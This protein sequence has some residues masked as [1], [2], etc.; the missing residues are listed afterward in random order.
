MSGE[1]PTWEYRWLDAADE[2]ELDRLGARGW[3]I[4]AT[5][6][7]ATGTRLCLK[8]QGPGFRERVTLDQ[9]RH[10]YATFGVALPEDER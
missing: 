8:R 9:K 10:V 1:H 2:G 6:P 3:E 5:L 4:A 7:G